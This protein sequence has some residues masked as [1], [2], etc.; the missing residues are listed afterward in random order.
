[1]VVNFIKGKR[2]SGRTTQ[3][4]ERINASEGISVYI[5]PTLREVTDKHLV[6]SLKEGTL[7][8]TVLMLE[9][10]ALRGR[11]I[12]HVFIDNADYLKPSQIYYLLDIFKYRDSITFVETE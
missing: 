6:E 1:M 3:V 2:Q 10:G 11:N 9:E 5:A 4:V 7:G 8:A 12:N